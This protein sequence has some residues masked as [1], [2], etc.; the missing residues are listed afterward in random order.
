MLPSELYK[1]AYLTQRPG[2]HP[3]TGENLTTLKYQVSH[4]YPRL[5]VVLSRW[6]EPLVQRHIKTYLKVIEQGNQFNNDHL[7]SDAVYSGIL[8]PNLRNSI[9][10]R[11]MK[12]QTYRR[13]EKLLKRHQVGSPSTSTAMT[14]RLTTITPY[15]R[16]RRL[17]NLPTSLLAIKSD[18][19]EQA[20]KKLQA[21]GL[22]GSV[23]ADLGFI[24]K[25]KDTSSELIQHLISAKI[26]DWSELIDVARE[27]ECSVK[28]L[29]KIMYG[30][31]TN[32]V[33]EIIDLISEAS[34]IVARYATFHY[35]PIGRAWYIFFRA[36]TNQGHYNLQATLDLFEEGDLERE[37]DEQIS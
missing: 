19:S 5:K 11:R 30:M 28:L 33:A 12:E 26:E 14:L 7:E 37:L 6:N 21:K 1:L 3:E 36:Y 10:T 24:I 13:L 17:D 32:D 2:Y 15:E 18:L 8:N 20:V 35:A 23:V 29:L 31:G 27:I 16:Q 22:E 9:R 25:D 34:P 4:Y